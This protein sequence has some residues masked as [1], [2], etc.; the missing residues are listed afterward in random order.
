MQQLTWEQSSLPDVIGAQSI[1]ASQEKKT[2]FAFD[3]ENLRAH[4]RNWLVHFNFLDWEGLYESC[5]MEDCASNLSTGD[6]FKMEH[7]RTSSKQQKLRYK[8]ITY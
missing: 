5:C 1:L 7:R 8:T 2:Y 6:S 4:K 3:I